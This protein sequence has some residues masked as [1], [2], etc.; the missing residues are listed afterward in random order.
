MLS[1]YHQKADDLSSYFI[2]DNGDN[3]DER[4]FIQIN[5]HRN[6]KAK[7]SLQSGKT[8]KSSKSHLSL[9]KRLMKTGGALGGAR[10]DQTYN[11]I[12]VSAQQNANEGLLMRLIEL[13][14]LQLKKQEER[15]QSKNQK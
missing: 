2:T 8:S 7:Q 4:S 11:N 15:E 13:K 12:Q 6:Q 3:V 14:T 5:Q 10:L 9:Y 1:E